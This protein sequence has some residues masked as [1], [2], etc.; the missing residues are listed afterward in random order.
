[1]KIQVGR[2][3]GD[4]KPN[5]P[6][7]GTGRRIYEL[8]RSQMADGT[9]PVGA[10]IPST[11]ALAAELGVSRTTVTAIYEQLAAEGFITTSPGRVARVVADPVVTDGPARSRQRPGRPLPVSNSACRLAR[12]ETPAPPSPV[13]PMIDFRYGALAGADFPVRVWRRQ[14]QAELVRQADRLDYI[15]PAGDSSLRRALQGYLG[16]ARGIACDAEQVV[17]VNGSQ[18][19]IDLCAR[20]LLDRDDAFVFEE[21][22]YLMA[23]CCFEATGARFIAAPVDEYGLDTNRLPADDGIRAAFVTP[24][25]QF[26]PGRSPAHR[27]PAAAFCNGPGGKEHGSSRTITTASSAMAKGR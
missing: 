4:D 5:H 21:P 2:L 22:G 6:S 7:G 16:R 10:H 18:Q 25:H 23:R 11:R 14:Y 9:L 27:A 3:K 12:S 19:A 24:S 1:M 13:P 26:P 20:L 17:V 15:E 8:L